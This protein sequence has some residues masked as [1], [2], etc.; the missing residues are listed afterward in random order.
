M[1][2]TSRPVMVVLVIVVAGAGAL[3]PR[4]LAQKPPK[5]VDS[6][7]PSKKPAKA[8][9]N[10]LQATVKAVDSAGKSITVFLAG[11][12]KKPAEETTLSLS[13]DVKVLLPAAAKDSPKEGKLSELSEGSRVGLRLSADGKSVAVITLFPPTV[14]GVIKALD[15]AKKSMTVEVRDK[16]PAEEQTYSLATDVKITLAGG[17]KDSPVQGK[18]AD[19]T[20][21]AAVVLTLSANRQQVEA[22]VV[23][24]PTARGT[25]KKVEA[26]S[27][28]IQLQ[29]KDANPAEQSYSLA[30]DVQVFLPADR[31][32][33]SAEGKLADLAPGTS[34]VLTLAADGK[35][36]VS[37]QAE[38]PQLHG[39]LRAADVGKNTI[40]L[41]IA[42]KKDEPPQEQT[43][44]LAK[45]AA[46]T[47]DGK[48]V[49]LDELPRDALVFLALS[50]D[51]KTAVAVR[52]EGGSVRGIVRGA[53][54][55]SITIA[56]KQGDQSYSLARE[57]TVSIDGKAG[58]LA[59]VPAEAVASIRLSADGKTAVSVLVEGP[60][61][62][63][64]V[65]GVDAN[66]HTITLTVQVDKNNT[67]DRTYPLARDARLATQI[68]GVPVKLGDLQSEKEVLLQL[69]AD[70]KVVRRVTLL[71][72]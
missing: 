21:G 57:A 49:R 58:P 37:I 66:Q 67:E 60:S 10:E 11:K 22:I 48:A 68:Y 28:T 30:N 25:I 72:E 51:R 54:A 47:M 55:S 23:Q 2:K 39:V 40:T 71:G 9:G 46:V 69:S 27:I 4:A 61:I 56:G 1:K 62:R 33:A 34:V 44:P 17:R 63:G 42:V 41:A 29:A 5:P 18:A 31:K 3:L 26:G 20:P 19:L 24:P 8:E 59:S 38:R 32:E 12:E 43:F 64:K 13:A 35:S 36:V 50:A 65:K 45:E 16:K 70:Q 15:P 6:A 53:D 7:A 52:A 14:A